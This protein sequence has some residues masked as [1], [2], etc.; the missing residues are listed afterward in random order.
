MPD[1]VIVLFMLT[2]LAAAMSTL[3]S[4]FHTMGSAAGHDL[5]I[6]LKNRKTKDTYE[7]ISQ[8]RS[9]MTATKLGTGIMIVASVALAFVMPGSIIARATAM[10]MGICAVSFLPLFTHAL[11][12]KRVSLIGAKASLIVG[13]GGMVPLD[14]LRPYRRISAAGHQQIPDRERCHPGQPL[15]GDRPDRHRPA[16]VR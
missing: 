9:S 2:L 10:F 5:W 14:G 13:V 7:K 1:I 12:S 4:I 11:F 6:H 3:S 16:A 8:A 15:A